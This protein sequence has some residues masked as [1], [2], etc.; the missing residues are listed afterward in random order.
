VKLLL[1]GMNHRTAPVAFRERFAVQ[2]P[3][4]FF[5]RLLAF[6]E[7][8]EAAIISTCN[9]IEVILL[10][11]RDRIDWGSEWLRY[12]FFRQLA[13]DEPLPAHDSLE[14][15]FYE[16]REREVVRHLFRVSA[17]LDSLVVGEP[18]IL[19]QIKDAYRIAQ[20]N[21]ALGKVLSRIFEHAFATA[22]RVRHETQIAEGAVSVARVAVSLGKQI[23]ENF[24]GKTA[25][26]IG[27]GEM[28][29]AAVKAL[30]VEGLSSIRIA[31]RTFSRA[32]HLAAEF[33]GT[34]HTLEEIPT[35]LQEADV[36]L[37]CI[38]GDGTILD[39]PQM[40]GVAKLRRGKPLFVI[41]IG[42]PRN[43]AADVGEIDNVYLYD[44][45]DL[46]EAAEMNAQ[47]RREAMFLA[48]EIILEEEAEVTR[49]LSSLQV[50]PTIRELCATAE[51]IRQQ[52]QNKTFARLDLDEQQ[53]KAVEALTRSIV[54]KLLHVPLV[55]L[56]ESGASED[57]AKHVEAAR[58]LFGL[59]HEEEERNPSEGGQGEKIPVRS[60]SLSSGEDS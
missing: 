23:F 41:D 31:N 21:K 20:E 49:W 5:P 50:V 18:Q 14:Q 33:S 19:G 22:K 56:R 11:D 17:S 29:E 60:T 6:E 45:D 37:T 26:L 34:A 40:T 32:E 55:R 54:N 44:V 16:H 10:L 28:I 46:S 13:G 30:Q 59:Q 15:M 25:L 1:V 27:A 2:D 12:E 52:E 7:I 39:K 38:G 47:Q 51:Q 42:V 4:E 43:V 8:R 57:G 3:S 9:R 58:H 53:Q 35:L 36:V 24:E 48:E